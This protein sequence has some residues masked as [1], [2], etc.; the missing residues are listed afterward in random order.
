MKLDQEKKKL[1]EDIHNSIIDK[2]KNANVP[3]IF[4]TSDCAEDEWIGKDL[5]TNELKKL[6]FIPNDGGTEIID[7]TDGNEITHVH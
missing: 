3:M 5:N 4:K 7:I 1:L 6:K 2:Y